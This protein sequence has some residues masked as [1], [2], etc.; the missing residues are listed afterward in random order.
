LHLFRAEGCRMQV[1]GSDQWGNITLG[2][3]LIRRMHGAE[4]YGLAWPLLTRADGSKFGKSE[5]GSI[6]LAADKTSPYQFF[7]YWLNTPDADAARYLLLFTDLPHPEVEALAGASPEQRA[8]QRQL[9]WDLPAAVH[10]AGAAEAARGA[11][12]VLFGG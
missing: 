5:G 2:M 4:A 7:Q 8:A 6:W 9:A 12:A 1:G 11:A 10:G 3:D